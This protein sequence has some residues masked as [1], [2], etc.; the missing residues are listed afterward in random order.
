MAASTAA[1]ERGVGVGET[2]SLVRTRLREVVG[3]GVVGVVRDSCDG[4]FAVA[5]GGARNNV[6]AIVLGCPGDG[7]GAVAEFVKG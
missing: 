5:N 7:R 2:V 1:T 4:W 6:G 3:G